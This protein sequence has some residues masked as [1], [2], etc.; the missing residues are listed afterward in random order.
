MT[1]YS[2]AVARGAVSAA[3]RSLRGYFQDVGNSTGILSLYGDANHAARNWML[4]NSNTTT[5]FAFLV[6]LELSRR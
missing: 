1:T 4:N 6:L 3:A 5:M 2:P